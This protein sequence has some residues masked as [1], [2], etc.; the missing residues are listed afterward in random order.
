MTSIPSIR[1]SVLIG[2]LIASSALN[3]CAL[4]VGGVALGS[5][6]VVTDRRT[7]GA[8][9]DDQAIELK[10]VNRIGE[11]LGD[12]GHVNVTSFNRLDTSS[13]LRRLK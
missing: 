5:A 6:M 11:V 12:R 1:R 8:Q 10:S 9:V 3:G 13:L 2:A 4:L 7:S